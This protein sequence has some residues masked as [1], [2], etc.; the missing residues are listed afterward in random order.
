MEHIL[1]L[2]D[3]EPI[4]EGGWRVCYHHPLDPDK[5]IKV[6]R[7]PN[8][9]SVT[10]K[11]VRLLK[12]FYSRG[13]SFDLITRYYGQ[14]KTDKGPGYIFRLVR[15]YDGRISRSVRYYLEKKNETAIPEDLSHGLIELKRFMLSEGIIVGMLEDHNM[16]YQYIASGKGRVVLVDGVGNHQFLPVANFFKSA[17]RRVLKR[18]W[19]TFECQLLSDYGHNEHVVRIVENIRGAC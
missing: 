15:D 11:E 9:M 7:I 4:G 5:C 10:I 2:H 16:L 12:R 18:K 17:A 19:K 13:V 8:K 14:V 6:D 1:F 3:A